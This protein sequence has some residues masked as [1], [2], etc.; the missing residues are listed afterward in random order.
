MNP[1]FNLDSFD[2]K[3]YLNGRAKLVE[4]WLN[5]NLPTPVG[6]H[7]PLI[8]A[9]RY[10]ALS[11]GKRIRPILLMAAVDAVGGNGPHYIAAASAIECIH[12]Y[13]LIHDDLPAMDDDDLRRGKPTCHKV[14]GEAMAVLA[15]DGL[16]NFAFEILSNS[17]LHPGVSERIVLEVIRVIGEASGISGMVGGQ[18][19]DV[20][21]EGKEVDEKTLN[22]IHTHKTGALIR[23]SL[24]S[25]AL[26]GG[27]MEEKVEALTKFGFFLGLLFQIKDDLLDIEG[28]EKVVGKRLGKDAKMKKA[29]YPSIYGVEATKEK[30]KSLLEQS[31]NLLS[32]FGKEANPLRA[33]AQYVVNRKR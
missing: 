5:A 19:A 21:M 29:T 15:G 4:E 31:L 11:G 25:G 6:P 2:L 1:P 33:I 12:T 13:S 14:F 26:L 18:A 17:H 20:L 28:D 9:M 32:D 10:S 7:A 3:G 30:A 16:L 23:A 22:F 27:G 8:E 24:R